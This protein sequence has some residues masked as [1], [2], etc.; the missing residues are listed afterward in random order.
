MNITRPRWFDLSCEGSCVL[1]SI[2]DLFNSRSFNTIDLNNDYDKISSSVV[3]DHDII[4]ECD[5][6][7]NSKEYFFQ[8]SIHVIQ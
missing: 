6:G 1:Q 7:Y 8:K 4:S 3:Y 2:D 5:D